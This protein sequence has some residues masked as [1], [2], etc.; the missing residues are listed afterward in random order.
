MKTYLTEFLCFQVSYVKAID[1]WMAVCL[2]FVFSAL[3]EYAAVNFVSRQ[4][5]ELLR[6]RRSKSKSKVPKA[7][8]DTVRDAHVR[9]H[10]WSE[11]STWWRRA[12]TAAQE[13]RKSDR[14]L[15]TCEQGQEEAPEC[16]CVRSLLCRCMIQHGCSCICV[17][18]WL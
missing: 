18:S 8:N 11:P 9:L 5:K 1:I 2:L 3:L 13:T 7:K 4:H 17:E 15:Q 6:F 12:V 14:S 16:A 10:V